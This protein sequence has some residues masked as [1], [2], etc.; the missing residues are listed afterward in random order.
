MSIIVVNSLLSVSSSLPY[1][2]LG[3][4][5]I[6]F[7]GICSSC[8]CYHTR[9]MILLSTNLLPLHRTLFCS[10]WTLCTNRCTPVSHMWYDGITTASTLD[11]LKP[12]THPFTGC[13]WFGTCWLMRWWP[14][15]LTT[16][17]D[18]FCDNIHQLIQLWWNFS[19][20]HFK[21]GHTRANHR[22]P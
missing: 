2:P 13:I 22:V 16:F 17:Y 4:S 12:W 3:D 1:Y 19:D 14:T 7:G 21:D 8:P 18:I 10:T 9:C 11:L 5:L 20:A 15:R 6:S